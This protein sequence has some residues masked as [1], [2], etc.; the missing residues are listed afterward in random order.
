[1]VLG[2]QRASYSGRTGWQCFEGSSSITSIGYEVWLRFSQQGI[3]L[4]GR[5]LEFLAYSSSAL[6]QHAVWFV[7][8]FE[9][10]GRQVNA[11]SIRK[12]LGD[13]SKDETKPAKM[14]ARMARKHASLYKRRFISFR[15]AHCRGVHC[16]QPKCDLGTR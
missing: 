16:N 13:F 4:A 7:I 1:M 12:S 5:H 11:E 8:P 15:S 14:A 6:R 3:H 10:D 9:K 2:C